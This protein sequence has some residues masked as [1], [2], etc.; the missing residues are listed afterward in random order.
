MS[1]KQSRS[2]SRTGRGRREERPSTRSS[3]D[4]GGHCSETDTNSMVVYVQPHTRAISS[5]AVSG[6]TPTTVFVADDSTPVPPL[7]LSAALDRK[8]GIT[9]AP[10]F[11]TAHSGGARIFGA[12]RR[13]WSP[14]PSM[15]S[16]VLPSNTG[17]T[18]WDSVG[19][20][21]VRP[22]QS[23]HGHGARVVQP[24]PQPRTLEQWR[25]TQIAQE[26][27]RRLE[28]LLVQHIE[29]EKDRIRKIAFGAHSR[30]GSTAS[31]SS[32]PA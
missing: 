14:A 20:V 6:S 32:S 25:E 23:D 18:P 13:D 26:E 29:D 27:A 2:R 11:D 21:A 4:A 22:V 10:M 3:E 24:Q 31:A 9:N 12:L 19:S 1:S 5:T 8:R 28:G 15:R 16:A 30:R 17:A 7:S